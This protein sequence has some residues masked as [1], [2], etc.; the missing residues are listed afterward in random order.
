MAGGARSRRDTARHTGI[1]LPRHPAAVSPGHLR[2]GRRL[3]RHW[4]EPRRRWL[5]GAVDRA[6][7]RVP[8]ARV[9]PRHPERAVRRYRRRRAGGARSAHP[10]LPRCQARPA[11]A[12]RARLRGRGRY[13]P[14]RPALPAGPACLRHGQRAGVVC[15]GAAHAAPCHQQGHVRLAR[16]DRRRHRHDRRTA[17]WR[18][19]RAAPG[20]RARAHRFPGAARAASRPRAPG[21]DAAPDRGD[22]ADQYVRA[23]DR[24]GH[25]HGHGSAQAAGA[26]AAS[27]RGRHRAARAGAGCRCAEP[28]GRGPRACR[29]AWRRPAGRA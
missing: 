23:G 28:A 14:A 5:H 6:P 1:R 21:A 15:S 4:P 7:C 11:H 19:C 16:R 9:L 22:R 10:H 2:A 3:V 13:R 27:Q 29:H 8:A 12:R 25:G 26:V 20:R 18:A 24:P 17:A